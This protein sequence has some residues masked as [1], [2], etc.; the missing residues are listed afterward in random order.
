MATVAPVLMTLP[1]AGRWLVQN[2]P[3][4]R[5]PSHGV[6]VF[7]Q[8]YA[9]DFVEVDERGRTAATQDWRTLLA[10]EPP[11][12]FSAFGTP[13]SA[14]VAGVVVAVH[15]GEP[16]HEARR[17]Q[18]A[19]IRYAAGQAGRL[20]EGPHAVA[21]NHVI[22]RDRVSGMLVAMVH[23]RAGSMR[24]G[25]GDEVAVGDPVAQCGN[26]GNSTQP[27]LHVQAMDSADLRVARG[28]PIAFTGYRQWG[29]GRRGVVREVDAGIPDEGAVVAASGIHP[30]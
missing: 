22:L 10:T 26:S 20:R 3:A 25:V 4:R 24:V 8:R 23:L 27:H 16:D 5:D 1:F 28:V 12:R 18:L 14:P 29:P 7:G 11:E 30:G 6:D 2:S 13:L 17:S 15:D 21:G 19:L 9:I